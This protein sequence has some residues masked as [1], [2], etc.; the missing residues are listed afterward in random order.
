MAHSPPTEETLPVP[1]DSTDT[2]IRIQPA[3]DPLD[4][5]NIETHTRRLHRLDSPNEST[6]FLNGLLQNEEPPTIEWLLIGNEDELSYYVRTVPSETL[7]RLEGALRGL[8]PN[9]YAFERVQ[10]SRV[11]LF[12]GVSL[13]PS[14]DT[15]IQMPSVAIEYERHTTHRRDWQTRLTPFNHFY[16][17]EQTHL[18]LTSVTETIANSPYPVVFQTLIRAKP[19]WST[20]LETRQLAL[21]DGTDTLGGTL[22][23]AIFG[24]PEADVKHLTATDEQ[25]LLELT[26]RDPRHSFE[27]N[28]R[29]AVG[30]KAADETRGVSPTDIAHDL[31]TAF[32]HLNQTTYELDGRVLT[33]ESALDV[34]DDI[35]ATDFRENT[36]NGGCVWW[37]TSQTHCNS[38][39]LVYSS[40]GLTGPLY[41]ERILSPSRHCQ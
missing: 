8:F 25:R 22:T 16:E 15:D 6:G 31:E 41:C 17:S 18:P 37:R 23:N 27:V 3:T 13:D 1:A 7:D 20:E 12:S 21:E 4:P 5:D 33:G 35:E 40:F 11:H 36:R 26:E 9:A 39:R 14:A 10:L 24:A 2:Y 32:T 19:D 30:S 29:A 38:P 34:V 28:C